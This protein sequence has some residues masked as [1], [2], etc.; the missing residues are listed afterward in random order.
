MIINSEHTTLW[1]YRYSASLTH[2]QYTCIYITLMTLL[3]LMMTFLGRGRDPLA[4]EQVHE[5]GG[6]SGQF[7][8]LG[9]QSPC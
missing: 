4:T 1:M 3:W 5:R 6:I 9:V 7:R 8:D 2:I